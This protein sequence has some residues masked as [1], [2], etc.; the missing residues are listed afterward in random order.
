MTDQLE[1]EVARDVTRLED[2]TPI[3][4]AHDGVFDSRKLRFEIC[5]LFLHLGYRYRHPR[6][7]LDPFEQFLHLGNN[8]QPFLFELMVSSRLFDEPASTISLLV[9]HF[10]GIIPLILVEPCGSKAFFNKQK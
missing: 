10:N 3:H 1:T 5:Q 8:L 2:T 7:V 6:L 9:T 4:V